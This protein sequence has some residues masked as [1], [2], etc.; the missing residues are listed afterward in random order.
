MYTTGLE[1]LSS[2]VLVFHAGTAY[3]QCNQ[4]ITNGGRVL[5]VT[6][7]EDTLERAALRAVDS[8]SQIH[9]DGIYYRKD[10]AYSAITSR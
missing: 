9:F 6:A 4:L 2:D 10:I 7:I 8:V 5:A 1:S 3:N